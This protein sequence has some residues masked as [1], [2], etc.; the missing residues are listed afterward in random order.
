[1]NTKKEIA[2]VGGGISGLV[3]AFELSENSN[4]DITIIEGSDSCGGK[5]KG[6]FNKNTNR[7]EEHSIR[8]LGSTYFAFFDVLHRA[9]LLHVLTAVD[10]YKFYESKTGKSVSVDRTETLKLDTFKELVS[11]FNLSVTDMLSLAKKIA[12]H[13]NA[14]DEERKRQ[15]HL[16]AGDVIGIDHFNEHTKQF[17]INWF[18]ILTGARMESK[19]V[20]IMDSFVLMFLP[21]IESPNLP[22][23][24]HSKSYCFNRPTSEVVAMLVDKLQS[25]GVKFQYNTRLENIQHDKNLAKTTL[26]T[27]GE[28]MANNTFDACI[29]AIPHEVMWKLGLMHDVK[30]PF[31]DEWSFGTQFSMQQIPEAF[32]E[33]SGKSYNLSFDA[34]WNIVFQIQHQGA[35]WEDVAFPQDKPYNLSATCSSPFNEGSLYGKRFMECTPEEVKHEILFQLGIT[36]VEE[37]KVLMKDAVIDPIYLEY[38]KDWEKYAT[39][40]TAELG[41]MHDDGH[42]WVNFSQIYVRSAEDK[43]INVETEM[44]GIFLAGEVVSVP[45]RWKIPTM[46]Q[47]SMS[48]KQAAQEVYK[49]LGSD[50]K[51]NMD[52]AILSSTRGFKLMEGILT[53]LTTLSKL[54]PNTKN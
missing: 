43:E 1:M 7:F 40:E 27:S 37:R 44:K 3:S 39:L 53:G 25:R 51:V 15:A 26:V 30:K 16:K 33:F 12:S 31:N 32:K 2:I 11:T 10:D 38:T 36:S 19:A 45:G 24:K 4:I 9:D 23:G 29:M 46:E 49:F 21:M 50:V 20:D 54:I 17:I 52:F 6:Y 5:M 47:A 22:P 8:A 13:V 34:P 28:K 35:F 48:G 18:G 14:S 42:R 41:I